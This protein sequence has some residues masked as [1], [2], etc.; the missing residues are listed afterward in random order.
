MRDLE[1]EIHK[2][3]TFRIYCATTRRSIFIITQEKTIIAKR[4][5]DLFA[6]HPQYG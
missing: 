5:A 1:R 2:M 6:T 3:L 4:N